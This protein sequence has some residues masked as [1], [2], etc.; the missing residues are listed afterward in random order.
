VPAASSVDRFRRS[1]LLAAPA[2]LVGAC[3]AAPSSG[4]DELARSL[5][6][7][8]AAEDER[9]FLAGFAPNAG[10]QALGHRMFATLSQAPTNITAGDAGH[11]R[12][13]WSLTGEPRV[14]SEAR[15]DLVG[16]LI[17]N[18]VATTSGTEWLGPPPGVHAAPALVVAAGT[19]EHLSRWSRAAEA[20]LTALRGVT[21]PGREWAEPVVVMVPDSLIGFSSYA[22]AGADRLGAVTV[23]P[24]LASSESVRVVVN[25]TVRQKSADDRVL[26]THEA[27]HA[28][29]RSP[30]LTGTPGWLVEGIAEAFT[31]DAHPQ[32]AATNRR[33]A[34]D[35][36]EDGLPR[37][38][39]DLSTVTPATY[40]LAQHAVQAMVAQ[41]GWPAVL[42]EADARTRGGG[43]RIADAKVLGWYRDA[44][45][46]LA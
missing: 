24:G 9:G 20:A 34:R 32:V 11:L 17:A 38:L 39:P 15:A 18:L 16:G 43:A 36:I 21:P 23:V 46:R 2:L 42:D 12:V 29:M 14:Y 37:E 7:R 6:E 40:A 33:L 8:L 31:A 41:V 25:P 13:A 10:A 45:A 1:L 26:L 30:R 5:T 4:L 3:T 22:G 27:V 19:A 28:W 35:A 44:L